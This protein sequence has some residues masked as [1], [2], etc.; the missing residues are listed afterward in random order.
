MIQE[1]LKDDVWSERERVGLAGHV[2]RLDPD[3]GAEIALHLLNELETSAGRAADLALLAELGLAPRYDEILTDLE[4]KVYDDRRA[5]IRALGYLAES[6]AAETLEPPPTDVL[7][8]VIEDENEWIR[9]RGVFGLSLALRRAE[10]EARQPIIEAL[11]ER[12]RSDSSETVRK[13]AK[14]G[15][16]A[17]SA[18]CLRS[19][20]DPRCDVS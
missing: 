1:A 3:L 4:T 20:D 13:A 8:G 10:G 19:T 17:V 15:L 9:W 11:C 6:E 7:L 5:A 18:E 12:S 16:E 14:A 2:A